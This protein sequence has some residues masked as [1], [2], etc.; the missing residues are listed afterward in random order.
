MNEFT[1]STVIVTGGSRGIGRAIAKNFF[2]KGASVLICSRDE[3]SVLSV[4]GEIDPSG[5]RFLGMAAD[6]SKIKDCQK[7]ID[8]AVNQFGGI[9]ILINNAGISGEVN[10]FENIDLQKWSDT[11]SVNLLGM[12]NCARLVT[13]IMKNGGGG[14]IINFAGGGVGSKN[15]MPNFSAYYTSKVAVVGFTETVA[16]ELSQVNIQMNAVAPGAVNTGITDYIISQGP[17][18]VG[19]VM[20]QK[21]LE[22]KKNGGESTDNIVSLINFL[23]SEQANNI[24]GCLLSAKW[25]KIEILKD[26][27]QN[28]DRFKLRRIDNYLFY[29]K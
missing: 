29:A 19:E 6:V 18:K 21:S 1:G 8:A 20:Y 27:K 12:V 16:A 23:C 9:N 10:A 11:I 17:K 13:P 14:K 4:C 26:G 28:N 15:T 24:N 2:D 5:K 7:I 22:Q 3:Q 25:D